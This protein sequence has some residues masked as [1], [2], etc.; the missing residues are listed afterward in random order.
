M[1]PAW[2][3]LK[4]R[5]IVQWALAYLAGAWVVLQLL[6]VVAEPW[7][8]GSG[9]LLAA[10]IILAFGFL[11]TL[12]LAWYHGEQGRQRVSGPELLMLAALLVIAGGVIALVRGEGGTEPSLTDEAQVAVETGGASDSIPERSVAVLPLDNHSPDPGDAYFAPAMTEAL[13]NALQKVPELFVPARNSAEQFTASGMTL[14]EFALEELGVAHVIEGSVQLQDRRA[15]IT[16]QLIDARTEGHVWSRDYEEEL[17]DVL[18]VQVDVARQVADRMAA[19]FSERE[20][21]RILAGATDDPVAQEAYLRASSLGA[22]TVDE[23]DERYAL[24]RRAVRR[25]PEFSLAW[26]L[27]GTTHFFQ[28]LAS[29]EARWQDSLRCAFDRAIEGADNAPLRVRFEATRALMLGEDREG[30][31]SLLTE[32]VRTYPNDDQLAMSLS[33]AHWYVGDLAQATLWNRRALALDPLNVRHRVRLAS[34]YRDLGL[35]S[36]AVAELRRAIEI[37]PESTDPWSEFVN[38]HLLSGDLERARAAVDTLYAREDPVA[39]VDDARVR[40]H[41]G[42]VEGAY[43]SFRK[44]TADGLPRPPAWMPTMAYTALTQG[45]SAF[46][47]RLFDTVRARIGDQPPDP[48]LAQSELEIAAASGD[49]D[50]SVRLLD[51]YRAVGGRFARYIRVSPVFSRVRDDP[52]FEASLAELEEI[53]ARQRRQVE[54]RLAS[55]RP[56]G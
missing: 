56:G 2:A 35:D 50:G 47:A 21:E 48:V 46:A 17:I 22:A 37:A 16:V 24:L 53:V 39:L 8:I 33:T 55:E 30:A 13:T 52:E 44:F 43:S 12:V 51:R 27:L 5:K 15:R 32:A 25:D 31:I 42:D 23:T 19:S 34:F 7:G 36:A 4:K 20:R 28:R 40:L 1:M 6:D 11:A 18:D 14:G 9:L 49:V 3:D 26:A 38:L 29:G 54:R 41:T 10:Q 45:D